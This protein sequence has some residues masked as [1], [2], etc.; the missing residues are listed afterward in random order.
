VLVN[1]ADKDGRY[2]IANCAICPV[3][4]SVTYDYK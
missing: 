4:G 1:A 3:G 2:D